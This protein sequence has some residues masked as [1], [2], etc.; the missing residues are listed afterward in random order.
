MPGRRV[1]PN[2]SAMGSSDLRAYNGSF[3]SGLEH[4]WNNSSTTNT[5]GP[6]GSSSLLPSSDADGWSSNQRNRSWPSR[7]QA[8]GINTSPVHSRSVDTNGISLVNGT[9]T[10]SFS[11]S[12]QPYAGASRSGEGN[13]MDLRHFARGP[14]TTGYQAQSG[15]AT[16][17]T[18]ADENGSLNM[19]ISQEALQQ[20]TSRNGYAHASHNSTSLIAAQ[21]PAHNHFPSFHSERQFEQV[22]TGLDRLQL[23]ETQN[24]S[25]RPQYISR[26][27]LDASLSRY[28][29]SDTTGENGYPA[30]H[31]M[32][33]ADLA[34]AGSNHDAQ[35]PYQH[36]RPSRLFDASFVSPAEHTA[37]EGSYYTTRPNATNSAQLYR[38]AQGPQFTDGLVVQGSRMRELQSLD[39]SSALQ[40]QAFA[41]TYDHGFHAQP[42]IS[43]QTFAHTL[44]FN[45]AA[46]PPRRP[47]SHSRPT[48][49]D[50][51]SSPFL[52]EFRALWN[53]SRHQDVKIK[54]CFG[55]VCEL[56]GDQVGSRALQVK[57]ETANSDEKEQV[58]QEVLPNCM[59][60]SQDIFGNYVVQK[61]FE[62]G[63]QA[64]KKLLVQRM[65]G[66]ILSLSS[67]PYGCRVIQKALEHVLV[68]QQAWMVKELQE[69]VLECVQNNNGNHVIQKAIE[70]VPSQHT[71]FIVNAFLGSVEK[72]ATHSYGCRVIQRM[73]E[74]CEESDRRSLLAELHACTDKLIEDQFGNYVI[75]HVIQRG[76]E[77]DRS[78]MIEVVKKKVVSHSKHKFASNV[79]EK[80]LDYGN[81]TQRREIIDQLIAETPANTLVLNELVGDQ[82][83]NYVVQTILNH[84]EGEER[85]RLV[86]RVRPL[87]AQLKRFSC[88]KQIAALEKLIGDLSPEPTVAVPASNHSSTTP[89]NSH[90]SSP[91]PSRRSV[92]DRFVE[93]PPTP[94][95]TD[96]QIDGANLTS[97]A[98]D[99]RAFTTTL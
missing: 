94:P 49:Q 22:S 30:Q 65:K 80:S 3:G 99:S 29:H 7:P 95:P 50:S 77:E 55:H 91:Q 35:L 5:E 13:V 10:S 15:H 21:R 84:L 28:R 60:L 70:R 20:L 38:E 61:L 96:N 39:S 81:E 46:N 88:G 31:M 98:P 8:N 58:F 1:Q 67:A 43:S 9:D 83:G 69:K 11:R 47:A 62:H 66:N 54:I 45:T 75:Q 86:E 27:S 44:H 2:G 25:S 34:L 71:K 57:L 56:S 26:N 51:Q 90:K 64:Q 6:S 72:Q 93:A 19:S 74:H 73:L 87:L 78:R 76:E 52:Q 53:R 23:N 89:P 92:E 41:P 32:L 16:P 12:G 4:I 79:V 33:P 82:Y 97:S 48:A 37:G 24:A 40:Q 18:R 14:A 42:S 17:N 36:V 85:L 68:D 59:Q 63:N